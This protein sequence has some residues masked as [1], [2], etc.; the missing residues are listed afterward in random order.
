MSELISF[1]KGYVKKKRRKCCLLFTLYA[2]YSL[3]FDHLQQILLNSHLH[4]FF[5]DQSY[6][7]FRSF[8]QTRALRDEIVD[9]FKIS[10]DLVRIGIIV[11]IQLV[12]QPNFFMNKCFRFG[13]E[14]FFPIAVNITC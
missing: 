4:N 12:E 7:T 14:R 1:P 2:M 5:L 13:C 10:D 6:S 11:D 9:F 3:K 8:S